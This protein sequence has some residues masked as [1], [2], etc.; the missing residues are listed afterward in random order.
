MRLKDFNIFILFAV[1]AIS[2]Q[3]QHTVS[4]TVISAKTNQPIAKA[5]V[6]NQTTGEMV[7]TKQDGTFKM[8]QIPS[9]IN[10]FVVFTFEYELEEKS[11]KISEDSVV[12]FQLETLGQQLSEVMII[13]RK[14]KVFDLRRLKS[15]EGTA[16]YEGKKTE[17]VLM[18]QI[19]ANLASNKARQIYAQV[20]GLN[21]YE[22]SVAGLQ[23]NIGG[24]GLNPNRSANFNIRQNGYDIS[25]DALGYPE[26]YYTPPAAGLEEIQIIRGAASLQ[27]GPQFG[28]LINFIMK[29]PNPNE[30]IEIVSRQST[31]SNNLFASFNSLGGTLGKFSYYTF[32]NYKSGKGFRENSDYSSRNYYGYFGYQL[33]DKTS[34]AFEITLFNYLAQQPGGL[35]DAQFYE[36]PSFSN[37]SRNWFDVDWKLFAFKLKHQFSKKTDFSL[38][39]F[40][41]DAARKAL[42]YRQNRVSQPDNLEAPRELLVDN[43]NNWGAEARILTR[44]NLLNN[45]SV[46]LLGSKFY[47]THNTQKQGPGTSGSGPNFSFATEEFPYFSRQASFTYPNLNVAFFGENIFKLTNE[48]SITPGFRFEYI[49]T[50]SKGTYK[51]IVLDLAGNPI[52]NETLTDNRIFERSFVLF[53]VGLNYEPNPVMSFYGNI[54]Q[55]YRSVTF[56]DIRIVNPSFQIDEN[57]HDEEG[58]TA[59]FGMNGKYKDIVSY[60]VGGFALLYDGRIGEVLREEKRV[61]AEGELESTG[62][63]VRY[64]GNIGKAL[65]YG[66]EIFADWNIWK[67]FSEN[68]SYRMNYFINTAITKSTYLASE[69]PGVEGNEV[70]FVPLFNIKTGIGFGYKNF[71]GSVQATFLSK[72]FTD[73]SN[74][75]QDKNDNQRG[76][77]GAIPAYSVMD[78]SLSYKFGRFKIETGINNLLNNSYFT[79]RATGYPGPGIIPAQP[80]TWYVTLQI[81]I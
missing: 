22:S 61:N 28:G 69:I 52:L 63:V 67:T 41:L 46:L 56:S 74:A 11:I 42:G 71:L 5:E 36:D 57:I 39:V 3:A 77:E 14:E 76:I 21:I 27:Y 49:K 2:T 81:K 65:I 13:A 43:F 68:D 70:E 55:N 33:S 29:K 48:F 38:T 80:Q 34:V 4:G 78:L 44:Y 32:F 62:S 9:G 45:E 37:R 30:K 26:S 23:L 72:Q 58:F 1:I 25:A 19:T 51:N 35:T 53:G 31:G 7:V 24:R 8:T 59:D 64:R 18:D 12:N 50:E 54:S 66:A 60:D 75:P 15:V 40:G 79:Q 16:I 10:N 17:V 47:K 20:V 73:A 6:Y